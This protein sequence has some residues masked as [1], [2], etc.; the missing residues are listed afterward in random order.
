MKCHRMDEEFHAR[1]AAVAQRQCRQKWKSRVALMVVADMIV[2]FAVV[3]LFVLARRRIAVV[4]LLHRPVGGVVVRLL[5]VV[6]MVVR[7]LIVGV[8]VP[9]R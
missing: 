8:V 9:L 5:M 4:V 1:V 3:P 2:L 7:R 6:V